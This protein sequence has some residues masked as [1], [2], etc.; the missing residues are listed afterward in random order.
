MSCGA[1]KTS[2]GA[3]VGG[4]VALS[5]MADFYSDRSNPLKQEV[6]SAGQRACWC[7][8]GG[9]GCFMCGAMGHESVELGLSAH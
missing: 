8:G 1:G 7:T 6:R 4:N 5:R 3:A 2:Q 9:T